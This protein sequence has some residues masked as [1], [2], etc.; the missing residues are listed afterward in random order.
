MTK[1]R[2]PGREIPRIM[3]VLSWAAIPL[4]RGIQRIDVSG[5]ENLPAAG[6]FIV[7]SNHTSHLDG[8]VIAVA[9]YE[10][11]IP[12][13]FVA[14]KELFTGPLGA[15]LRAAEQVE[16]DRD[17]PVGL[18]EQM[19]D[20]LDRDQPLIIF[21]EGTFTHD[22]AGWPMRAKTGIARLHE[23]RPDVPIIPVATWGNERIVHPWTGRISLSRIIHRS[24]HVLVRIGPPIT[25]TGQTLQEKSDS[26]MRSL[27]ADVAEL[28]TLLGRPMGDPPA[29]LYV[30]GEL[31]YHARRAAKKT[32]RP[33]RFR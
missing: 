20:V 27:A 28:R 11:G 4:T 7:V 23:M 12:P 14:K 15:I 31:N 21:P 32:R 2:R 16:I 17:K 3:R 6:P 24:E 9:L 1:S 29:A 26:V 22:P 33:A 13:R 18:I 10:A 5:Q 19:A 25:L 8:F 30:P